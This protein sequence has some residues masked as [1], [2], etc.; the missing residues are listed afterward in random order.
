MRKIVKWWRRRE[1][2]PIQVIDKE[3]LTNDKYPTEPG[4]KSSAFSTLDLA[5]QIQE[6]PESDTFQTDFQQN[7]D[8][9]EGRFCGHCVAQSSGP[10]CFWAAER[11]INHT[12]SEP[13]AGAEVDDFKL[14]VTLWPQL[15]KEVRKSVLRIIQGEDTS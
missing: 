12:N 7:P 3:G 11:D 2:N 6:K 4:Q 14:V 9:V 15:S 5:T 13:M 1:S 10:H 8:T